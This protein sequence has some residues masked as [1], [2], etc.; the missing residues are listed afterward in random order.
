[1]LNNHFDNV[2]ENISFAAYYTNV[3]NKITELNA[4]D[5]NCT[6]SSI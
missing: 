2:Y 5:P 3:S 1:M 6:Y 4:L